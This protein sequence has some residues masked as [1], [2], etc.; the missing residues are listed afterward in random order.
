[1]QSWEPDADLGASQ[2]VCSEEVLITGSISVE[3]RWPLEVGQPELA[4]QTHM[5]VKEVGKK[6]F[7]RETTTK[8]TKVLGDSQW[9]FLLPMKLSCH[10][11]ERKIPE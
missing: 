9:W 10:S 6:L 2:L 8:N 7:S 3:S 4:S 1:M 11:V 5:M